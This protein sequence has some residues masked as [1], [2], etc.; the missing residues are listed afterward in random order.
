MVNTDY[1]CAIK[2]SNNNITF[3]KVAI[4]TSPE[5]V[6]TLEGMVTNRSVTVLDMQAQMGCAF[7][8]ASRQYIDYLSP[9]SYLDSYVSGISYPSALTLD[10]YNELIAEKGKKLE[11]DYDSSFDSLRHSDPARFQSEKSR[12]TSTGLGAYEQNLKASYLRTAKRYINAFSYKTTLSQLK[13]QGNIR[14]YSTDTVGWSEFEYQ[15]TNEVKISVSTN[16]GYGSSAYFI[17]GMSYKGIDILPYSYLVKYYNANMRDLLRYTRRYEVA[18]SSWEVAFDYVQKASNMANKD[19]AQFVRTYVMEEVNQMLYGLKAILQDSTQYADQLVKKAGEDCDCDYLT[20]RNMDRYEKR[21]FEVYPEE[22]TMVIKSEKVTGA[23]DFLEN[24][25]K[26]AVHIPEITDA[27]K[28]IRELAQVLSPELVSYIGKLDGQIDHLDDRIA[29]AKEAIAEIEG[30]LAPHE[31]EID[32]LYEAAKAEKAEGECIFWSTFQQQYIQG[33]PE[34]L[35]LK[36]EL[37]AL[38]S[39]YYKFVEERSMRNSFRNSLQ[40]CQRKM[41]ADEERMAA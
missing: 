10:E 39:P 14:M 15:I 38:M 33:H 29:E 19:A 41:E 35:E 28:E 24:L 18:R 37:G 40:E 20:V 13:E 31:K 8:P 26:L 6:A 30:R 12:I 1:I 5:L 21:T 3:E 34:Y 25:L 2:E 36:D 17:L 22:M 32:A 16:F 27:V 11:T 4:P 7:P 9:F 23:L